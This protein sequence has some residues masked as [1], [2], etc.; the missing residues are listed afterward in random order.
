[1]FLTV[2]MGTLRQENKLRA[3]RHTVSTRSPQLTAIMS[4][5]TVMSMFHVQSS[6]YESTQGNHSLIK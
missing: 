2:S 1:M 5:S 6:E 4:L 3:N